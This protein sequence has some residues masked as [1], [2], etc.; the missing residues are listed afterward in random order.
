MLAA[1]VLAAAA[2]TGCGATTE[3]SSG[4]FKGEE[5]LVANTIEDLQSEGQKREAS[6][7]C[8]ELL[9]IE[10]ANKI[11]DA[12]N[13]KKCSDALHRSLLDADT[14]EVT[15]TRVNVAG[16]RATA[17]VRSG[18]KGDDHRTDT[19]R[20]VKVGTPRRWR[21]SALGPGPG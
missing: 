17:V 8:S 16:N 3:D 10:L 18:D 2:V 15:V 6:T 9:T 11:R 14:W 7:I 5:R 21:V 20:L 4:K 13:K 19:L 1:A 12:H